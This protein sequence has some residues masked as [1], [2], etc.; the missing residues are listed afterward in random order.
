MP[1]A[2][3]KLNRFIPATKN[4]HMG[5][6]CSKLSQVPQSVVCKFIFSAHKK[7][8][9]AEVLRIMDMLLPV[10]VPAD[11]LNNADYVVTLREPEGETT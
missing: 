1:N 10:L 8:E 4:V 3:E 9:L 2:H 7:L 6:T 11:S 5:I